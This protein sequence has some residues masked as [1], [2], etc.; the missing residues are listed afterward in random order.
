MANKMRRKHAASFK[1]QAALSA[2]VGDKTLTEQTQQ[3][4]GH[5]NR[6]TD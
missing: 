5:P 3:V 2:L 6:L 4:A 1:A